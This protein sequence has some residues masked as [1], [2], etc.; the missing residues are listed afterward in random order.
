[1]ADT[2]PSVGSAEPVPAVTNDALPSARESAPAPD[3]P[4]PELT[5]PEI[6]LDW[7]SL[8]SEWLSALSFDPA[9]AV[10]LVD[11]G[12]PVVLVLVV[13]SVASLTVILLKLGQFLFRG[14]GSARASEAALKLWFTDNTDGALKRLRRTRTPNGR[15]LAHAMAGISN[16][17]SEPIVREDA[18]RVAIAE[19]SAAKSSL[20]VLESIAQL[21]P[22]LGLFGT[23]IGMMGAFQSLQNS[24]ADADPAVLAGGIWVALITT[25]VGLAVAIPTSFALYWFEG[26]IERETTLIET[27]LTSMFTGRLVNTRA[28]VPKP[29]RETV[30][31]E[32]PHA[33]E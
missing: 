2:E 27:T 26:R 31:L 9:T 23:V 25:A 12:G 14:V 28:E 7:R 22:L 4:A 29:L 1:M 3:L 5:V 33:A 24:G 6:T 17:V 20:R 11:R 18:E 8:P 19:L 21:A 16:G 30:V 32:R 13:L 10:S 15:V